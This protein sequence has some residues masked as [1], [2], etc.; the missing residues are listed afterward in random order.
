[1]V[2]VLGKVSIEEL[3]TFVSVFATRGAAKRG[4]HGCR[5]SQVF[6]AADDENTVYVLLQWDSRE[7]FDAFRAD[8]SVPET[9]KSGGMIGPPEFTFLE[10]V[11]EFPT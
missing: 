3:P 10:K 2:Y 6:R 11:A 1:M 5:G 7:A 9:M 4:E 8:P